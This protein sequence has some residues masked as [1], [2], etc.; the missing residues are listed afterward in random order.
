LGFSAA[1]IDSLHASGAVPKAKD[2]AA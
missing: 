2:Q 1:E